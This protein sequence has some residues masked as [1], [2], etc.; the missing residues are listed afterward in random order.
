MKKLL[1]TAIA[2]LVFTQI[3][4]GQWAT[5]GSGNAYNNNSTGKVGI[6]LS[7]TDPQTLEI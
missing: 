1:T 3:S 6:G 5:S 7:L 2:V 4:Y